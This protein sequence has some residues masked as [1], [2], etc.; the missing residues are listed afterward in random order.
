MPLGSGCII[1]STVVDVRKGCSGAESF[2]DILIKTRTG[3][4]S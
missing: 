2:A 4:Y 1:G 3:K